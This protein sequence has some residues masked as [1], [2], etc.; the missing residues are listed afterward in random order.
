ML[1]TKKVAA[2]LLYMAEHERPIVNRMLG[3]RVF[4]DVLSLA[5]HEFAG[6]SVEE[7]EKFKKPEYTMSEAEQYIDARLEQMRRAH[8]EELKE[9]EDRAD[10]YERKFKAVREAVERS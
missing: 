2:L 8:A 5:E 1:D 10:M 9:A 7:R 6:M 4:T 3:M